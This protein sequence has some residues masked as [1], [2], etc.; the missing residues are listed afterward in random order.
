MFGT[1]DTALIS[2]WLYYVFMALY[3]LTIVGILSVVVSENRNPVKTLSWVTVLLLLPGV[4]IVLYIFFGR[5]IKNKRMISRRNR[6]RLKR[7]RSEGAA[8]VD[9]KQLPF[10]DSTRRQIRMARSLTGKYYYPG[11]DIKIFTDGGSKFE[12]LE[13]DIR[14]ARHSINIQYYIFEDDNLGRR[15]RDLL[16]E[17]ARQGVKVR[18]IYDHVG[19]FHVRSKFFR[20]MRDAGVEVY[21]FFRVTFR[22]LGSRL[23][24]RNHRKIVVIDNRVAYIGGMNVADRYIDGGSFGRWRD[25]HLR[26]EGP[27]AQAMQ[28]SFAVDWNF[29][30]QPLIADDPRATA[31]LSGDDGVQLV[32][33]GPTNQWS[34]VELMFH[35]AIANARERVY[36]QTPYFIPTEGLF[37]ALITASLSGVDVRVMIPLHPDS[38]ILRY[39]S[40]SYVTECLRAGVKIYFYLPGM[41]HSK[42]LIIDSEVTSV[43]STNFDFRSFEHNFEANLFIYSSAFNKRMTD[44]FLDDQK[45]CRRIVPAEWSKRPRYRKILESLLRLLS[46]IL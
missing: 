45:E 42:V 30:G 6:R 14:S 3:V 31:Q 10:N 12:A 29:M 15:L 1:I 2:S 32:T 37:K 26:V 41:L 22:I 16:I 35:H 5:S 13:N 9:I 4:G 38:A 28:Y 8:H 44:I 7:M 34:N 20:E 19:S 36:I 25:T 46:P 11:N 21:P 17:K 43:G 23:N 33:A 39:A 40:F 27:G 24:W 18:L